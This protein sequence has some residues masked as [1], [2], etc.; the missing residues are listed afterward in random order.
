[1]HAID[2]H[3]VSGTLLVAIPFFVILFFSIFGA[4]LVKGR[5][6]RKRGPQR[7][8]SGIDK[9]GKPILSDPDGRRWKR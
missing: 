8:P 4:D 3:P 1:M 5:R 6:S 9:D 7:P 2:S